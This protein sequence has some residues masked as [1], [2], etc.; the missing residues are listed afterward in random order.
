MIIEYILNMAFELSASA[1]IFVPKKSIKDSAVATPAVATTAVA[2]PAVAT[3][4][5]A[6]SAV[7]TPAPD[8][9]SAY[10]ESMIKCF[11]GLPPVCPPIKYDE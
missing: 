9:P 2:T 11:E 3:S 1:P 10:L 8:I 7:A 4:A 5:V 6:T